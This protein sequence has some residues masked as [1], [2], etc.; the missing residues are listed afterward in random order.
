MTMN[1]MFVIFSILVGCRLQRTKQK[2][3]QPFVIYPTSRGVPYTYD[4]VIID[5]NPKE[6][7]TQVS[8]GRQF[9]SSRS[10][11]SEN[12]WNSFHVFVYFKSKVTEIG[13]KF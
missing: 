7:E 11:S 12:V 9:R 10:D 13:R 6:Y 4:P 8:V 1:H 3:I 2:R 5:P